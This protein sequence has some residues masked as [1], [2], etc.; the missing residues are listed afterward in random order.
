MSDDAI[1]SLQPLG[2]PWACQDPFLF[3]VYHE[4]AFPAGNEQLAPAVP[5]Q[6]RNLGQDFDNIGGWNMYHGHTVPGFPQH[7]H[8]GFETVTVVRQGLID[9]HD[10]LGAVAR[11]GGGDAQWLTTGKGISHSEMFPLVNS[12]AG[13]PTELFQ[14]WLNLPPAKKLSKPNFT[15]V[16]SEAQ[17]LKDFGGAELRLIAGALAGLQAPP[18]PPDSWASQPGAGVVIATLK[19]APGAAWT[20]PAA[21]AGLNRT[22]YLFKGSAALAGKA[23][24][25]KSAARLKSDREVELKAGGEGCEMLLLQGKPIGAPVAQYGPFV[26][27]TQDELARAF[28]DYR[29]D[30]F[31]G[32]PWPD[33]APVLKKEDGRFARFP[34]GSELRP[35]A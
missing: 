24:E 33:D 18:P 32:W 21:A 7:P 23:A 12:K 28:Q 16:W 17:P 3:C 9:H 26:M 27:N 14:I 30:E 4:D 25:A 2:F 34:D 35:P 20:L 19:L 29:K 5:L 1:I 31:G 8:R 6:G 22:L 13:N 10:S 15:I 11:Y